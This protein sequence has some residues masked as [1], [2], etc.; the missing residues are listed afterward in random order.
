MRQAGGDKGGLT[1][2]SPTGLTSSMLSGTWPLPNPG[3]NGAGAAA[4][5]AAALTWDTAALSQASCKDTI[6]AQTPD[7]PHVRPGQ[8][9]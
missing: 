3:A 8:L 5:Q 1:E 6:S 9:L 2:T 7:T 4:S